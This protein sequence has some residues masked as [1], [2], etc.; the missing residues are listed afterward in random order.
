MKVKNIIDI[1]AKD[2]DDLIQ[3]INGR[4]VKDKGE[5]KLDNPAMKTLEETLRTKILRR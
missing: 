2:I 4:K 1:I 5:I 3:Q